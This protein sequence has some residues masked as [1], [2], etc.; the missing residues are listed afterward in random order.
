LLTIFAACYELVSLVQRAAAGLEAVHTMLTECVGGEWKRV[1]SFGIS[2]ARSK[3]VVTSGRC[4]AGKM[5]CGGD[6]VFPGLELDEL[7]AL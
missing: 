4:L 6:V 1:Q 3:T 7:Q 2:V 5:E